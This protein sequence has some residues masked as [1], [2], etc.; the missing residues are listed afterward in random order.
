M[1]TRNLVLLILCVTVTAPIVL[2]TDRFSASFKA[3][4]SRNQ[5]LEDLSAFTVGGDASHLNLLPQVTDLNQSENEIR[6]SY[7]DA[8]DKIK[9]SEQQNSDNDS[10]YGLNVKGLVSVQVV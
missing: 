7:G 4:S 1:K 9:A 6:K 10:K 2:Y 3:S 8:E 5:F